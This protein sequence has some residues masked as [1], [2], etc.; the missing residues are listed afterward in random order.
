[1]II[2]VW[3]LWVSLNRNFPGPFPARRKLI[4]HASA[5]FLIMAAIGLTCYAP[6]F[7]GVT[8]KLS[9]LSFWQES[10]RRIT[11]GRSNPFSIYPFVQAFF[12]TPLMMLICA[13]TGVLL[14]FRE[15]RK[16][17]L[18]SLLLFWL[19]IPLLIPCFPHTIVYHNGL[20]HFLVFLVPYSI[21]AVL[22]MV[23]CAGFLAEKLKCA[24]KPLAGGI[25]CVMV[26]L[27]L[28]GIA[29]THP[30]QTTFFN[31]LIGGL[32][33]AQEIALVDSWDYWL[34]SYK[35]AGAWINTHGTADANV[36][37]VYYSG[38]GSSFNTDLV[39]EAIDRADLKAVHLPSIPVWQNRIMVPENTYVIL[40]PFDY[41]Q[42]ARI[43]LEQSGEFQKVY[44][45]TRQGGEICTI[46][47]KP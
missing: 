10:I 18:S 33:G 11:W 19:F 23:R 3:A 35:E 30:Y 46:F 43:L 29:A 17:A 4:L 16:S 39:H 26:G 5:G 45:V 28:W 44:A 9:F 40:V 20:R 7:W 25:V 27:N 1:L 41:L 14:T 22:G 42:Q 8:D 24:A 36:V 32:K 34:N 13:A 37:G 15:C 6:A 38:T 2:G 47:Y 21:L 12:R 31:A